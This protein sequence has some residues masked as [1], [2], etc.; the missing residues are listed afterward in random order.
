MDRAGFVR[1]VLVGDHTSILIPDL[2]AWRRGGGGLRGLRC[3][4][5]HLGPGRGLDTED[6]TDLALLR[7]DAMA[8]V[9]VGETGHAGAVHFAALLPPNPDG[10]QWDVQTYPHPAAVD[11]PFDAF[12]RELEGEIRRIQ[13]ARDVEGQEER[14]ILVHAGGGP[15]H[16][17]E[18]SLAELAELARSANVRVVKT[19]WQRVTRYHP[20]HLI[21]RGKLREVLMEG[22]Y[23]GATLVVFDQDLTPVQANNI[24]RMMDLKVIDRTQLILDIFARRA[25]SREGKI[26]VELAQLRYL[27]PRL[28][29]RGT[30]MSRLMGG[31]GGRG[32]GETQLEV[33]RRRV[34][35]RIAGLE[36]E[37]RA[38]RKGR[39][40][41]RKHRARRG[42]PVVSIIGYTNAGK[43]TLLN[44]LTGSDVLAED[45]LFATLDPTSRRLSSPEGT[46][47]LL[48][49]TVGFIRHM[50]RDLRVAFRATLEE[51]ADAALFLHVVDAASPYRAEEIAA[52]ERILD[53]MG[54]QDVPRLL[55]C[56]KVDLLDPG[57]INGPCRGA[58]LVSAL[59]GRGLDELRTRLFAALRA[60]RPAA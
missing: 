41:R 7:L 56:N 17:A 23:L 16:E 22:L 59:E 31:I 4:H 10:R 29:G 60:A 58:V 13:G 11:L 54:L 33:D 25:R 19:V 14:A 47:V 8:A 26:Q 28:V 40:E 5:T 49:D 21:G 15:R 2:S 42:L 1:R 46:T 43:S 30:A 52:V 32:P 12:V 27:L 18:R 20:A 38:L 44:R 50:P 24:A 6:L 55:V 45:R 36:R 35:Q 9:E 53:E 34:K 39:R 57:R 3:L 51:L 37:L 48:A